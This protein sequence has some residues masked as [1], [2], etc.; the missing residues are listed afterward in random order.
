MKKILLIAML[1]SLVLLNS[2][3]AY[4]ANIYERP[5][6]LVEYNYKENFYDLPLET[7]SDTVIMTPVVCLFSATIEPIDKIC[8][9]TRFSENPKATITGVS[10]LPF[11]FLVQFVLGISFRLVDKGLFSW[12]L[13]SLET[14]PEETEEERV[15]LKNIKEKSPYIYQWL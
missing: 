9:P 10:Y 14:D 1:L 13:P 7:T 15:Y 5:K 11:E 12:W 4:F 6:E 2:G 3:C 8:F